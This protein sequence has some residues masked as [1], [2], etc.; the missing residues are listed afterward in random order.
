MTDLEKILGDHFAMQRAID[1]A[2][3]RARR[4]KQSVL[5]LG[6]VIDWALE[7]CP[8]ADRAY[9]RKEFE[10]RFSHRRGRR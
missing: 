9:L 3:R 6:Q 7:R 1:A 5:P 10:R 8:T 4:S 2:W